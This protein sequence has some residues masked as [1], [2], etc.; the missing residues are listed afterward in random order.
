[1]NNAHTHSNK[2]FTLPSDPNKALQEMMNTIDIL[3]DIY[4]KETQALENTD[5]QKFLEIQERKL[6]SADR[7]RQS[8][9]QMIARKDEMRNAD[10]ALKEH[11]KEMQDNF[12][13]LADKN[14]NALRRMQR[15]SER[16][17]NT[18]RNAAKK[19]VQ[20]K[21]SVAYSETGTLQK[22]NSKGISMGVSETA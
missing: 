22:N 12:S 1:M 16:L 18:L 3:R 17:G 7:Y 11:L 8:V 5:T 20:K 2:I 4:A 15:C 13:V 21:R 10:A 9:E 6:R 19:A 14:M